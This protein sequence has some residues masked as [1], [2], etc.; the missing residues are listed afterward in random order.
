[1]NFESPLNLA[2]FE[3]EMDS[4]AMCHGL[5]RVESREDFISLM[6]GQSL[7]ITGAAA[8]G[9]K[10][11]TGFKARKSS[12]LRTRWQVAVVGERIQGNTFQHLLGP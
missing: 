8:Y 1:M 11:I 10:R 12:S 2:E 3:K 4:L 6:Y 7:L 9:A 5:L